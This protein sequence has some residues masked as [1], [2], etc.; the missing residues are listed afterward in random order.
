MYARVH[1]PFILSKTCNLDTLTLLA[2]FWHRP[3][4]FRLDVNTKR[5]IYILRTKRVQQVLPFHLEGFEL[6]VLRGAKEALAQVQLL[7]SGEST[8]QVGKWLGGCYLQ[9]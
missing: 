5:S 7:G 2:Q 9:V 8:P 4:S 6:D 1:T 3:V